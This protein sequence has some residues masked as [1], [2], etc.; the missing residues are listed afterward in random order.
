MM[1][2]RARVEWAIERFHQPCLVEEFIPFGELTVLLIGNNPP[3]ALPAIQRPLDPATRLSC[4]V[5]RQPNAT[6]WLCPL[7]LTSALDAA[8]R[9]MATTM[10]GVL[11]CHDMA[12]VD[13]RVDEA[14]AVYFLEIN[15]LPSF[16]P[17]GSLGLL[18]EYMGTTYKHLVGR[19]LDAA[20]HRLHPTSATMNYELRTMNQ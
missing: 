1:A 17:E 16:D 18:A 8:A 15:P 14:G 12:R 9:D 10:F 19:I 5:A 4:H 13:L 20:L 11:G 6:A 2:L 3:Q 7:D